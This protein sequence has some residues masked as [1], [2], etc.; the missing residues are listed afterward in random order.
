MYPEIENQVLKNHQWTPLY[1]ATTTLFEQLSRGER[2]ALS[3]SI[4]LQ[5][6][7]IPPYV[8]ATK[9]DNGS[10]LV[11]L[12][13]NVFLEPD[14]SSLQKAQV[15]GLGWNKPNGKTPNYWK[16]VEGSLKAETIARYLVTTLRVVFELKTDSWFSFGTAPLD[17]EVASRSTFW[18]KLGAPSVV[19]L[20][21]HNHA[22]TV[23]GIS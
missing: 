18:H 10:F 7:G 12:S 5:D 14:I 3:I 11:E 2:E 23:E 9:Q 8:Q 13:S 22:E 6:F 1:D 21:D 15:D 20:P 17:L 19:C 4:G 16:E